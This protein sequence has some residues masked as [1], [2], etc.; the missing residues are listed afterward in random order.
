MVRL[1][2][3]EWCALIGPF[4]PR[5]VFPLQRRPLEGGGFFLAAAP[6]LATTSFFGGGASFP[7]FATAPA[8]L[9]RALAPSSLLPAL[10]AL[11]FLLGP[12]T[13][14]FST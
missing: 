5:E 4:D 14:V 7:F 9:S 2:P 3:L 13:L 11:A 1:G 10:L 6:C 12:G 8:L